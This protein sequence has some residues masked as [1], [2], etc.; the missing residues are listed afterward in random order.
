MKAVILAGG[1]GTRLRPVTYEIPKPLI[2]IQGKALLEHIIEILKPAGVDEVTISLF[3]LAD[4]IKEHFK[5][6]T[7]KGV[8]INFIV[9]EKPLGTAGWMRIIKPLKGD[10]LVVNGDV[11]FDFDIKRFV[12]FHKEKGGAGT[13][14]LKEV[15]DPSRFGVADL[16]GDRIARFIEKPKKEEAPSN[17]INAGYYV[18]N[19]KVFGMLPEDKDMIMF[20]KDVFPKL[21]EKG[22]L[23]GFKSEGQWF[24]TGTFEA[25]E[26]VI[27]EW[28]KK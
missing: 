19:E 25:W 14:A 23:Y 24:D 17:Y 5:D 2:P 10:F 20:E 15:D 22:L 12:D 7:Y 26:R 9:E 21:A 11:M 27:M 6:G 18:L 28:K 4:K 3:H 13:I 1:F 16:E 8:R